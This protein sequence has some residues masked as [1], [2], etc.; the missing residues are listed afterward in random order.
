MTEQTATRVLTARELIDDPIAAFGGS[1]TRMETSDPQ[2]LERLQL[3]GL[4]LRFEELRD[5]IPTLKKLADRQRIEAID[6]VAD[7]IPLLFDHTMYKSYPSQLLTEKRFDRLTE[8]LARLTAVDLGGVDASGC[9]SID[10]WLDTLDAQCELRVSHTSGTTGTLSIV[11]W[12]R[13]HID[14]LAVAMAMVY[15]QTFGVEEDVREAEPFEVVFPYFRDGGAMACRL[16][17]A[18]ERLIARGPERFHVLFEDRVSSDVLYLAA[19][20]RAATA[21]GQAHT[22]QIDPGLLA[23]KEEFEQLIARM[24]ERVEAFLA[25][26][27]T[28]LAGRRIW[29]FGM[30][31]MMFS[32]ADAGLRRGHRQ[33]FAADS[34]ITIA[35]GGKGW[36]PPEDCRDRILE[37]FGAG[38]LREM[39]GMSE[40]MLLC[41]RCSEGRFHLSPW[42]IPFVL[43]PDT[44]RP[45]PRE[46]VVTGRAAF[47][48]LSAPARWGGFVTGDEVTLHWD[49]TCPCG[50]TSRY[51][52]GHIE[53]YSEKRGGDDKI[54]CVATEEAHQEA[55]DY[56]TGIEQVG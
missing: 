14:Q 25:D 47:F 32:M 17:D 55:L 20:L 4:R 21:R 46:G 40:I 8:W 1:Y 53:R 22:L 18:A 35:G 39:Y 9:D 56:L 34:A 11:P 42:V 5:R 3:E 38:E 12:S 41:R 43:D 51:L 30:Q 28:N 13:D 33:V 37:F 44:S 36:V 19:R 48:D 2:T 7:V 16:N 54:S 24:P 45:L 26:A 6:D 29:A 49:H 52:D 50:R 15:G 27:A 31:Q 10:E 23:R